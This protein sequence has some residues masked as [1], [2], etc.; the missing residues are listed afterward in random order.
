M[1]YL[2]AIVFVFLFIRSALAQNSRKATV[3]INEVVAANNIADSIEMEEFLTSRGMN[4]RDK[5]PTPKFA[6]EDSVGKAA[7]N[8][9]HEAMINYKDGVFYGMREDSII[10]IDSLNKRSII[11]IKES[12]RLDTRRNWRLK[13]IIAD[14]IK[15]TDDEKAYINSEIDKMEQY[16]WKPGLLINANIIPRD[17]INKVLAV[18]K[19]DGLKYVTKGIDKLY[20]FGVPIFFRNDAYCLFYCGY[21]SG[22]EGSG[23]FTLYRKVNGRW[24]WWF[25]LVSWMT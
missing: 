16:S 11:S 5:P 8:M 12:Y 22:G 15:I 17:T 18:R 6:Y 3:F 24:R 23:S 7:V 14:S 4:H 1:K 9:M 21:S 25:T 19:F 10:Y 13:R 20:N 2:F